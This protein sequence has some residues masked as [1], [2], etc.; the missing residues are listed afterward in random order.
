PKDAYQGHLLACQREYSM[1]TIL[2]STQTDGEGI[3][4]PWA[5]IGGIRM[6][7]REMG[8]GSR[9]DMLNGHL[10]SWNWQKNL[11][12]GVLYKPAVIWVRD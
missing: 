5:H 3:E 8:P 1:E 9:E 12:L 11:T 6:S 4:R 10:G 7:M 2:G